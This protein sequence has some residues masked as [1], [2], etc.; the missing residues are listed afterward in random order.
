MLGPAPVVAAGAAVAA[1]K[2]Y[3]SGGYVGPRDG[4]IIGEA[5]PEFVQPLAVKID[6]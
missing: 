2:A 6:T 3:A 1:T 4:Y 5:A